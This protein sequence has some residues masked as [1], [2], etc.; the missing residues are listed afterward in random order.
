MQLL[1]TSDIYTSLE[2]D[3][4]E[5]TPKIRIISLIIKGILKLL[6]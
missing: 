4:K 6:F 3:L 5:T 2:T 1:Y